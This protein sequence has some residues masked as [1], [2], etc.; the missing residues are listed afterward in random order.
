MAGVSAPDPWAD[1]EARLLTPR[2]K[3]AMIL[4]RLDALLALMEESSLGLTPEERDLILT[5]RREQA[6]RDGAP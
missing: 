6:Q 3:F 2:D 5:V 1:C 4:D